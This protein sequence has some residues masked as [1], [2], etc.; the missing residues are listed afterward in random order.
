MQKERKDR[1]NLYIAERQKKRLEALSLE[2]NLPV[3]ELIRRS[4]DVYLAWNDK[5]YEEGATKLHPPTRP[6][7]SNPKR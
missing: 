5:T 1:I 6:P 7:C 4:I 2:E 3:S